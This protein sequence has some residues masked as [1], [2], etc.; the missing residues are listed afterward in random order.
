MNKHYLN[1]L[2]FAF[3]FFSLNLI[4]GQSSLEKDKIS[5]QI[6]NY[7]N[8]VRG[9]YKSIRWFCNDG[10]IKQPTCTMVR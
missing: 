6:K 10:T 2:F 5:L 1:L 4:S 8:D 9:T 7:K 3:C